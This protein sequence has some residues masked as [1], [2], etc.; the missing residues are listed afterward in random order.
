MVNPWILASPASRGIGFHFARQLLAT[1]SL[2]VIATART[3]LEGTRARILEGLEG[4]DKGQGKGGDGA[5]VAKRLEV[6]RV[7]VMGP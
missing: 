4:G 1:T 5:D 6:L 2:P 7:D 3:D